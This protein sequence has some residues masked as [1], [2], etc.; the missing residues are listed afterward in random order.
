MFPV[1]NVGSRQS[2]RERADNVTDVGYDRAAIVA[3]VRA[4]WDDGRRP[5]SALYGDGSAGQRIA[6]LLATAELSIEKRIAY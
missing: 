5:S 2:G 6:E 1:V 4:H 3:A